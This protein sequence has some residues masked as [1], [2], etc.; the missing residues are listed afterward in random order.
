MLE[1]LADAGANQSRTAER[2]GLSTELTPIAEFCNR[3]IAGRY[4]FAPGR[5]VRRAAGRLRPVLR[6]RRH[7]WTTST[8]AACRTLVDTGANPWVYKPLA[9]GSK[10]PGGGAALADFQRAAKIKEAYFR[11]GGKQPGFKVDLRVIEMSD[12]MKT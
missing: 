9:D 6:R 11:A 10:P 12:G 5:E 1:T 2:Q 3:T 8:R 7:A 4:P